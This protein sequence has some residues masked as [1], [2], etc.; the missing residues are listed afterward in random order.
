[1]DTAYS[2]L[3]SFDIGRTQSDASE[4]TA[5]EKATPGAA[6]LHG[7]DVLVRAKQAASV[8]PPFACLPQ[9]LRAPALTRFIGPTHDCLLPC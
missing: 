4:D 1:M 5:Q 7:Y 9:L 6:A 2:R 8:C 3:Q